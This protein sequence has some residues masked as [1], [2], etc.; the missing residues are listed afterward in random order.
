[1][2]PCPNKRAPDLDFHSLDESSV[3]PNGTRVMP[4]LR[5]G[6]DPRGRSARTVRADGP[7]GRSAQTVCAEGP[8]GR[9]ARMVRADGVCA[10]AGIQIA[11]YCVLGDPLGLIS[12][13]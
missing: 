5:F 9:S 10:D 7:R 2:G 4:L 3:R 8:R 11:P 13:T 12:W 6:D 1:M